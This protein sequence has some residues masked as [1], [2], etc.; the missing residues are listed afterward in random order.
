M[1]LL[2]GRCRLITIAPAKKPRRHAADGGIRGHILDDNRSGA[3]Y[4]GLPHGNSGQQGGIGSDIRPG[5]HTHRLDFKLRLDD[6]DVQS[7]TRMLRSQHLCAGSP[8]DMVSQDEV[9]G[10]EIALRPDPDHV[11]NDEGSVETAL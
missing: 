5:F 2:R 3:H 11:A 7:L 8:A 10:I 1:F 6:W 9:A 4:A